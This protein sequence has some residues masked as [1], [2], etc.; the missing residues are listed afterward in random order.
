[1]RLFSFRKLFCEDAELTSTAVNQ[2]VRSDEPVMLL[3]IPRNAAVPSP[4]RRYLET[5]AGRHA[6][7]TYKCRTREPWY[8]VPDVRFPDL[9]L[10]YMAGRKPKLVLNSAAATCTNAV[11]AVAMRDKSLI[12]PVLQAWDSAFVTLSCEIE[13]HA[14]GGG[15]LKLELKEAARILV[16]SP[17]MARTLKGPEV[18]DAIATM[19]A[20]R[21][22]GVQADTRPRP[23]PDNR[24]H[25]SEG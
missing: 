18:Q 23:S 3:H 9:F 24:R 5:A 1:M 15:M 19:R 14:L 11:H 12:D 22:R 13:G 4:V 6:R 8:S 7:A 20:W 17:R 10:S 2:W 25:P 21:H 16:P